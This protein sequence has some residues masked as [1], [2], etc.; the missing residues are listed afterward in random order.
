MRDAESSGIMVCTPYDIR[1]AGWPETLESAIRHATRDTDGVYIS[2]DIDC[3]NFAV[4]PGTSVVNAG[5]LLAHELTDAIFEIASRTKIIGMDVV[6]VSPP[7]DLSGNTA[8][9]AAH[10]ILN[11]LAG[12]A[13]YSASN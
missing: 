5:G 10:V 12:Y 3:L 8:K 6:E 4:A 11:F 1:R 7:L 13:R 9:V 2:V